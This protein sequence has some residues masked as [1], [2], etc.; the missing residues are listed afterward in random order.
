MR[1]ETVLLAAFAGLAVA[2]SNLTF[3]SSSIV[4]TSS[5]IP[6]NGTNATATGKHNLNSSAAMCGKLTAIF[7]VPTGSATET[8]TE[9]ASVTGTDEPSATS[10]SPSSSDSDAPSNGNLYT[11]NSFGAFVLAIGVMAAGQ[12]I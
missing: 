9:T 12:L 7:A 6:L 1:F 8:E 2:Q 4:P 3:T 5:M 10:D 11:A